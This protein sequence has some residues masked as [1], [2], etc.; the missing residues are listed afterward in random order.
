M[1]K[2]SSTFGLSAEKLADLLK[3]GS[4][5]GRAEDRADTESRK[6]R[7]LRGWLSARLPLDAVLVESL[8]RILERVCRQLQPLA[9]ESFG[10]LLQ[11]PQADIEPIKKIKD[12]SKRLVKSAKSDAEHEAA[13]AIYY[14]AIANALLFHERRI[15]K[16]SY[17]HL[18]DTF[19][20]LSQSSWISPELVGLFKKARR[21]C[22]AKAKRKRE[23]T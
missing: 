4:D 5:T 6:A 18:E 23:R 9:H 11:D 7:L 20:Q 16:L 14:A 21:L 10:K 13:A 1:D 22:K 2:S 3:I 15:T 12:Y 19:L 17:E 8:P